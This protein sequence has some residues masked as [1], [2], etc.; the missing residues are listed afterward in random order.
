[1][2]PA[3]EIARRLDEAL[4]IE[5]VERS[6]RGE[7]AERWRYKDGS[8]E[9]GIIASVTRPF[10]GDCSRASVTPDGRLVACPQNRTT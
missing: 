4:G 1:M 2:L 6:Y 7:V 10:C 9:L 5:P 8:G 3:A